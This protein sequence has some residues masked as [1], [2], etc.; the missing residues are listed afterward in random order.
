MSYDLIVLR[1]AQKAMLHLP[2]SDFL[3][4]RDA[5]ASLTTN[6]RPAGCKRL[7]GRDAWRIRVG[8]Y[9]AIYE[10]DDSKTTVTILHVRNRRD[11]YS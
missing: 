5:L 7:K 11:A 6:P 10:I 3:R 8:P 4:V 2:K 1:R 9:R